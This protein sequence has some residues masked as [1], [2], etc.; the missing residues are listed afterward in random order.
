MRES[1]G[2]SGG[3]CAAGGRVGVDGSA[4]CAK[5]GAV[6]CGGGPEAAC[7]WLAVS[8]EV[9][10]NAAAQMAISSRDWR[11]AIGAAEY[12]EVRC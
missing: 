7:R 8:Q 12:L 5:V 4:V 3:C 2:S 11:T 1:T 9:S 6:A 10:R